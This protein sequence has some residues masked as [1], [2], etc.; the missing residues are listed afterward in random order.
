MYAIRS[1]Y[2]LVQESDYLFLAQQYQQCEKYDSAAYAFSEYNK[3][4]GQLINTQQYLNLIQSL[5]E[6]VPNYSISSLSTNSDYSEMGPCIYKNHLLFSS[7]RPILK[8]KKEEDANRGGRF[9]SLFDV[10][11]DSVVEEPEADFFSSR[12]NFV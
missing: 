10:S 12:N 1:Y 2:D 7:N 6:K 11:M 3:L 4:K 5:K 9:Y 8:T